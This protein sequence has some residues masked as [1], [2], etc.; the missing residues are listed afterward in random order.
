MHPSK[1]VNVG[2]LVEVQVLGV[3]EGNRRI[4]LGLKQTEP[5][6]WEELAAEASD[7]QHGQGQGQVDHRL[8]RVRRNRTGNRR[9]GPYLGPVVDQEG[10]PSFRGLQEG[11]RGR[12]GRARHRRRERARE[13]RGQAAHADPW[14]ERG[15]ALSA[16]HAG[17]R[18]GQ[19]GRGL[20]R[21]RRAGGRNRGT[22][23]HL[24]AQQ[25]AGRQAILAV[26][27]RR[28][29]RSAGGAGRQPRS[30]ASGS[31][32]RRSSSTR[33][34]RRCRPISSASTRRRAFRSKTS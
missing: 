20:R 11:R 22:D 19:L 9:P 32:S 24:A 10:A 30:G 34:A 14:Y 31:R 18:Q 16:Q 2:D 8:R 28:R 17:Q 13:S 33:S 25:R 7:R 26:Q 27:G 15:A 6:P 12:G 1:V 4:S 5:N 3:D 23:S 29:A 21:V